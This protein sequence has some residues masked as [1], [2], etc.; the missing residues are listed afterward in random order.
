MSRSGG[1]GR[2]DKITTQDRLLD[3][4]ASSIGSREPEDEMDLSGLG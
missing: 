3:T 2:S 4:R 1:W